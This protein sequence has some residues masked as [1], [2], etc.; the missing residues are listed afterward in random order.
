[1]PEPRARLAS[2]WPALA[3]VVLVAAILRYP[4]LDQVPPGLNFD[5]GGEGVAALDVAHGIYRIW[6]P[7]GG[8]KEPLMAYLVQPLF[9]LFGPT[10]LALRLYTA[11]MGILA[12][13]GTFWVAWEMLRPDSRVRDGPPQPARPMDLA[14]PLVA[15]LSLA[16]AFWH[17]AY[18]RIAFRAL[19]MPAVEALAVAWLWHA[20]RRTTQGNSR[21]RNG[22]WLHFAAAGACIGLG[23]YTYL[24]GRFV[25][26][27]IVFYLGVEAALAGMARQPPLVRCRWRGLLVAGLAALL[28]FAPLGVYFATHPAAFL[29]RAGAVSIFSPAWQQGNLVGTLLTT[30]GTTLGTF[31]G[32]TGDPNPLGNIPGQPMLPLPLAGCFWV[33]VSA[34]AWRVINALRRH[35]WDADTSDGLGSPRSALFL[36]CWWPVMLLPGVLA[37]EGAPHHL[38]LIGTA[39][40]TYTLVALGAAQLA[41]LV[42]RAARYPFPGL[43][44]R[45]ASS[46]SWPVAL[47]LPL[48]VFTPVGLLTAQD[49]FGRWTRQPELSMAFDVYAV[50]LAQAIAA[51][52]EPGVAYVIPM[53]LRAAHE[54]RHYSL[55][56]MYRGTTPYYYLPVDDRTVAEQ[57]TRA[58]DGAGS[59]RV[60]R[61][62]QDKHLAADER[63]VVT[64]LLAMTA[65]LVGETTQPVYR[66]ETWRLPSAHTSF[67]LP[68][69]DRPLDVVFGGQ[70]MLAAAHLESVRDQVGVALRWVPVSPMTVDYKASV[71][72][73][74]QAGRMVAQ[75]DRTLRHNWHQGTRLWPLDESVT[76]YYLLAPAGPGKYAVRVLVYEPDTLAPLIADDGAEVT[77]GDVTVGGTPRGEDGGSN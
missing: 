51:D 15:G 25:P 77:V 73:V 57:L 20:L 37:P 22:H 35:R 54:A 66:I 43:A 72:L 45:P 49:Y 30:L 5:E 63:E 55:D 53:D 71:R 75:R 28:I 4:A 17:V 69:P 62:T 24:A 11:T 68:L 21:W 41:V 60:V 23:A 16:T 61:W 31:A 14:V 50:E 34:C 27:A 44:Q 29:E 2:P 18:S 64:Y 59:L 12:V 52:T 70:I 7:I 10:R 32:L 74:D 39:P 33:G 46:P 76:E 58:A 26:L 38:R 47:V 19:A 3:L 48:V 65:Q 6:W 9:W 1:M 67:R 40:A 8:G 42:R 36:L 56:F 13:A